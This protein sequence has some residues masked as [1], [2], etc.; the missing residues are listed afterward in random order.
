[1]S[2]KKKKLFSVLSVALRDLRVE[3]LSLS[4]LSD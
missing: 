4:G 1:M 3:L 2:R